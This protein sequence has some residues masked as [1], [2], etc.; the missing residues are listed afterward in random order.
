M[1]KIFF[2]ADTHFNHKNIIKYCNRPF[3][4]VDEMNEVIINNWNSVVSDDDTIFFLGDFVLGNREQ[5]IEFGS[6]LKGHKILQV[7]NH[8][9]ATT[10]AFIDAGFE[11]VY[12]KPTIINFNEYGITV[13]ISHAPIY[14]REDNYFNICGHVHQE[15]INDANHFCVS[16]EQINYTPIELSKIVEYMKEVRKN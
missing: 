15:N 10:K 9:R 12:K 4:D 7:G 5:I 14:D 16:M 2:C 11:T 1:G 6:K 8:D 13:R 3:K